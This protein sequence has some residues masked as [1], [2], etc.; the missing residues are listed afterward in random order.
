MLSLATC[1]RGLISINV[2]KTKGILNATK[3]KSYITRG[4]CRE[5]GLLISGWLGC[6]R[7]FVHS[8]GD[9][10]T[11]ET[12]GQMN[13]MHRKQLSYE[14]IED[15]NLSTISPSNPVSPRSTTHNVDVYLPWSHRHFRYVPPSRCFFLN[16]M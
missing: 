13:L 4:V 12:R 10:I 16:M 7:L 5:C 8:A 11:F 14:P 1:A 2:Q 15:V 3:K 9:S 6:G